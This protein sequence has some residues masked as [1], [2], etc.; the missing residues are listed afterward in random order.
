MLFLRGISYVG[1][2]LRGGENIH[3]NVIKISLKILLRQ[4]VQEKTYYM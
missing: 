3:I 1:T 4:I 2:L